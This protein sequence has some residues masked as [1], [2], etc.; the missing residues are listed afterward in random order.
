LLEV[1][2]LFELIRDFFLVVSRIE[3]VGCAAVGFELLH[4][5]ILRTASLLLLKIIVRADLS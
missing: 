5:L 2:F 3:G 1:A 4:C